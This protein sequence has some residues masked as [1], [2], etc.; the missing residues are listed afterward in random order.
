MVKLFEAHS[1]GELENKVNEFEKTYSSILDFE[2]HSV[3]ITDG[4]YV[5]SV[6]ITDKSFN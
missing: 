4:L 1:L 6:T 3:S 5:M 2:E